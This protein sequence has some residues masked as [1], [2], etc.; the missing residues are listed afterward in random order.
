MTIKACPKRDMEPP[1]PAII[2]Y[3]VIGDLVGV[4]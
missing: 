2:V 4:W 1:H 3:I